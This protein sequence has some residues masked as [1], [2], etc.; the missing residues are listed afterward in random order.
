MKGTKVVSINATTFMK[1]NFSY[2]TYLQTPIKHK[3]LFE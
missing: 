3:V 1:V 2:V